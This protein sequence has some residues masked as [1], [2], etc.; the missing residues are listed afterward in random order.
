MC[1][2]TKKWTVRT[3]LHMLD[4]CLANSWVQERQERIAEGKRK[5]LIEFLDFRLAVSENLLF[6]G[7]MSEDE[8]NDDLRP[9]E[10]PP[11]KRIAL[12]VEV[13]RKHKAAH[14]PRMMSEMKNAARCRNPR[15]KTGKSRVICTTC[16]VF[17]CI[18]GC[19]EDFHR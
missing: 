4:L 8:D 19:F 16:K 3:V 7:D 9:G 14:M 2:R 5:E 18:C 17:L 6:C 10:E 13:A 11:P 1:A 12:P 15:C